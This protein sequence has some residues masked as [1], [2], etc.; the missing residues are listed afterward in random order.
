VAAI[1][2]IIAIIIAVA[3]GGDDGTKSGTATTVGGSVA[4]NGSGATIDTSTGP[5]TTGASSTGSASSTGGPTSSS[6]SAN[7]SDSSP[8]ATGSP[9][10]AGATTP[11]A[12]ASGG[13]TTPP[14]TASSAINLGSAANFAVLGNTAVIS[15][16]P[17]KLT[18]QIGASNGPATGLSA[19]DSS[20]GIIIVDSL[21]ASQ[22]QVAADEAVSELDGLTPTKLPSADLATQRIGPG[23]YSSATLGVSGTVTLDAGGDPNALFVFESASTLTVAAAGRIVLDG[24]AQACNVYWRTGSSA[25][26][27]SGSTFVGTVIA[28]ESITAASGSDVVGRFIARNGAVTLDSDS[29]AIPTCA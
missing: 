19:A 29:I 22:A 27:E 28:D 20:T 6:A 14:A 1:A 21:T 23:T 25:T 11:P 2:G 3:S 15:T 9:T 13:G 16:G 18:G 4:P 17:T 8:V 10:S 12:T 5:V 26:L 24:G 7:P